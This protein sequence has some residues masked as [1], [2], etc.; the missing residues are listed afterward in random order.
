MN[1]DDAEKER[2]RA[3]REIW[4]TIGLTAIAFAVVAFAVGALT[5]WQFIR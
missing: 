2:R 5:E 4:W 3:G 1:R